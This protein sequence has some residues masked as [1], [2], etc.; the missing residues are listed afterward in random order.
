M[1]IAASEVE[2]FDPD[3]SPSNDSRAFSTLLTT[4]SDNP[5]V[6]AKAFTTESKSWNIPLCVPLLDEGTGVPVAEG[7]E[8]A[9]DVLKPVIP[10]KRPARPEKY[11][12]F[13]V[14]VAVVVPEID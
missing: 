4:E 1:V 5:N 13:A 8:V 14:E 11:V 12:Y 9:V 2:V 10:E 6:R 7:N 3:T